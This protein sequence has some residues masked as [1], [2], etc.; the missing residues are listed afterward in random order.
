ML[1]LLLTFI[2]PTYLLKNRYGAKVLG[3]KVLLPFILPSTEAQIKIRQNST[4]P[5]IG[6]FWIV[7]HLL[8]MNI[9]TLAEM[10]CSTIIFLPSNSFR[11]HVSKN[12]L[13]TYFR[14]ANRKFFLFK[15][16]NMKPVIYWHF[17]EPH[18]LRVK[19][20]QTR[21]YSRSDWTVFGAAYYKLWL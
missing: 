10:V 13:T 1:S 17:V 9:K 21:V 5:F 16:T 20:R 15:L 14:K 2:F 7:W 12:N 11:Q 19:S 4:S 6:S 8:W 18:Q 3:A